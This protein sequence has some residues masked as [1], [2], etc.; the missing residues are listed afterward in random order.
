MKEE[1]LK[2]LFVYIEAKNIDNLLV[3]ELLNIC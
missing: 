1:S 2:F 3:E